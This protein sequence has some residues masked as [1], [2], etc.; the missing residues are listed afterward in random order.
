MT[1]PFAVEHFGY[2]LWAWLVCCIYIV[3]TSVGRNG[4]PWQ[5]GVYLTLSVVS[6]ITAY[7]PTR[8]L[9][10]IQ[11]TYNNALAQ[12]MLVVAASGLGLDRKKLRP[13]VLAVVTLFSFHALLQFAFPTSE[14][15]TPS[16]YWQGRAYAPLGSP[17]YLGAFLAIAGVW[18]L[19]GASWVYWIPWGLALAATRTRG[20][21]I[22]AIVGL[23]VA[24][25]KRIN[26]YA[27]AVAVTLVTVSWAIKHQT[28]TM[29]DSA[30]LSVWG[31]CCSAIEQRPWFGWG[32]ENA[33][34]GIQ[35]NRDERFDKLYGVT[36]QDHCHNQVLEAAITGGIPF[37]VVGAI[38]A[39]FV[40]LSM[41]G[42][43]GR[44]MV[45]AYLVAGTFNPIPLSAQVV[46]AIIFSANLRKSATLP[47][48]PIWLAAASLVL[49]LYCA[50]NSQIANSESLPLTI[51]LRAAK[52]VGIVE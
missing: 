23:V 17:V 2:T 28:A 48:R 24:N 19:P 49:A 32:P 8:A 14:W 13:V 11:G 29:S 43:T 50:R 52:A 4:I 42:D 33:Y 34:Y 5:F 12:T 46:A 31:V 20:A 26:F 7:N 9:L 25:R 36:S 1:P 47:I 27:I 22:A 35:A 37:A 41:T 51:R 18:A 38:L 3:Y 21:M 39:I 45:A 30:R 44:G 40:F 16:G 15:L 10:G 6:T